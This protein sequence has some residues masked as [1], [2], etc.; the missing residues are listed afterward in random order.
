MG[1]GGYFL[2]LGCPG[3]RAYPRATRIQWPFLAWA[4][5]AAGAR[6]PIIQLRSAAVWASG[7]SCASG[8]SLRREASG[9]F[10]GQNRV[11][12]CQRWESR[13]GK[14]DVPMRRTRAAPA[15]MKCG[16]QK[17]AAFQRFLGSNTNRG[18]ARGCPGDERPSER[19][20]MTGLIAGYATAMAGLFTRGWPPPS[21]SFTTSIA[22]RLTS[23]PARGDGQEGGGVRQ[24]RAEQHRRSESPSMRR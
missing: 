10:H 8:A 22:S 20:H 1:V 18:L 17:S 19:T 21:R 2:A 11:S 16:A 3:L 24:Q 5:R 13:R 7:R 15:T 9:R 4:T 14:F 12:E 6:G 23:N